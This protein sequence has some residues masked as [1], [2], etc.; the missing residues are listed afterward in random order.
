MHRR[1]IASAPGR[2]LTLRGAN[3]PSAA[4]VS[5]TTTMPTDRPRLSSVLDRD[6][7]APH[8]FHRLRPA[9]ERGRVGLHPAATPSTTLLQAP[10][11]AQPAPSQAV[12]MRAR[13]C[14]PVPSSS[15]RAY[16]SR[17]APPRAASSNSRAAD[18]QFFSAANASPAHCRAKYR[19]PLIR[20]RPASARAAAGSLCV[21]ATHREN[22]SPCASTGPAAGA[23]DAASNS[24]RIIRRRS[25]PPPPG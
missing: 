20:Q 21:R 11:R 14:R 23:C 18:G 5:R 2:Y 10:N 12:R 4:Q 19:P 17:T 3:R 24:V 22:R 15:Q 16:P 6:R 8:S 7:S 9:R 13:H 25:H 1:P